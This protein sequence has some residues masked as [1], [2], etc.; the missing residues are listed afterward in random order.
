[1]IRKEITKVQEIDD[2]LN[3]NKKK[4]KAQDITKLEKAKEKALKNAERV[5]TRKEPV[6]IEIER[7]VPED[8]E[9]VDMEV[10]SEEEV[11]VVKQKKKREKKTKPLSQSRMKAYGLVKEE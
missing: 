6:H 1:M 3:N 2:K 4:L 10:E 7:D 11:E 8:D 9:N 5:R